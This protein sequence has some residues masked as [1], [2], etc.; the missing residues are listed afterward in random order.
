MTSL[1]GETFSG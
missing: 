1:F